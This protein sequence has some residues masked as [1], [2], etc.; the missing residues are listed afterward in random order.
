MCGQAPDFIIQF[1]RLT[2]MAK[3]IKSLPLIFACLMLALSDV[4]SIRTEVVSSALHGDRTPDEIGETEA[5]VSLAKP[6]G[7]RLGKA[8]DALSKTGSDAW[9]KAKTRMAQGAEKGRTVAQQIGEH[10]RK[11]RGEPKSTEKNSS[12]EPSGSE[13]DRI[14]D[15]S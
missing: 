6:R 10:F 2:K 4:S 14:V 5:E 7:H 8:F 3:I 13:A 12:A 11:R 1:T 15:K 9:G